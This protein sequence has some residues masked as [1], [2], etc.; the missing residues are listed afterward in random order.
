MMDELVRSSRDPAVPP[1]ELFVAEAPP[2]PPAP[3]PDLTPQLAI[4]TWLG[5]GQPLAI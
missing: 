5:A 3:L 4:I 2:C 1:P